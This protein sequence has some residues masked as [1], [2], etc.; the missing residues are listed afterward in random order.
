MVLMRRTIASIPEHTVSRRRL[1]A[2]AYTIDKKDHG[3][4]RQQDNYLEY[5]EMVEEFSL[6]TL[7]NEE[8]E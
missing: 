3:L 7:R 6:E 1:F 5:A 4:A 8:T 2:I